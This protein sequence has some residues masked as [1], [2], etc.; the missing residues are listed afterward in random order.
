M[1]MRVVVPVEVVNERKK[2]NDSKK[3]NK[4]IAINVNSNDDQV[5]ES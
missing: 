2:E 4:V 1:E 3:R 5:V